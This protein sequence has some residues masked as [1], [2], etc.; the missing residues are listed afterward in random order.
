MCLDRCSLWNPRRTTSS[1]TFLGKS[2]SRHPFKEEQW[3]NIEMI[4][5]SLKA[6]STVSALAPFV[7]LLLLD[8]VSVLLV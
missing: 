3:N 7:G 2:F 6:T 1:R 5:I 4:H 8:N